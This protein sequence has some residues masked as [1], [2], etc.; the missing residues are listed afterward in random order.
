[1]N[2]FDKFVNESVIV[3]IAHRIG[4]DLTHDEVKLVD[5]E[6]LSESGEDLSQLSLTDGSI[7]VEDLVRTIVEV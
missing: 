7:S 5:G 4:F 2:L 1:M 6:S 3:H